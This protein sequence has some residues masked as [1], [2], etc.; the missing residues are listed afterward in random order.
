M[1]SHSILFFLSVMMMVK[2]KFDYK[3]EVLLVN[4]T[5]IIIVIHALIMSNFIDF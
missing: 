3:K 4:L 5:A 2:Y 1:L